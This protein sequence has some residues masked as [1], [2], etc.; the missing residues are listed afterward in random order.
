MTD[1]IN[2]NNSKSIQLESDSNKHTIEYLDNI[3]HNLCTNNVSDELL[4]IEIKFFLKNNHTEDIRKKYKN[5]LKRYPLS[6]NVIKDYY[7]YISN[8]LSLIPHIYRWK[9]IYPNKN[10]WKSNIGDQVIL[11]KKLKKQFLA[12]FDGTRSTNYL[13]LKLK[14]T[15]YNI[16][17]VE[18]MI[19]RLTL[20]YRLFKC[21]FFTKI[22]CN[23]IL[24]SEFVDLTF[25][26]QIE[27]ITNMFNKIE[28]ILTNSLMYFQLYESYRVQ[29]DNLLIPNDIDI[30]VINVSSELDTD[31]IIFILS[32]EYI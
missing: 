25:L 26:E 10:F 5:E 17:H 11:L 29:L 31:D 16:Y 3:I 14:T 18:E 1:Y 13:H 23:I 4:T 32:N 2:I 19:D 27:Y 22:K 21:N 9:L 12:I 7:H 20:L 15:N 6:S 24:L 30:G 8:Q 28:K